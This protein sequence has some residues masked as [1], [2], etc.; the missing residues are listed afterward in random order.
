MSKLKA[1]GKPMIDN[2][3]DI[4]MDDGTVMKMYCDMTSDGGGWTLVVSS[5]SNTWTSAEMVRERNISNPHLTEDYS[6]LKY[7]DKIKDSYLIASKTYEF[8]LEAQNR[9]MILLLISDACTLV[10]RVLLQIVSLIEF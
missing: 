8:K 1:E 9:G 10:D 2:V 3:Y 5:H 7:A 6:M 4:H